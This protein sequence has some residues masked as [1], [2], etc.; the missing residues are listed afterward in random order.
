[1]GT[2]DLALAPTDPA[3]GTFAADGGNLSIDG[4]WDVTALVAAPAGA[5][6]VP[7]AL[8]TR[9]PKQAV[10]ADTS[11]SPTI[12]TVALEGGK[13]AQVYVDPGRAG[14]NELHVT[15]FDAAGG[16][17]PVPTVSLVTVPA[18]G[19][20][21]LGEERELAPGHFVATVDLPPGEIEVDAVGLDP[22]GGQLHVSLVV[23]VTQ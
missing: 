3:A 2:S 1:V 13:S 18:D 12:Y 19:A 6:E 9:V 17:L 20:S 4:I 8:A 15:F 5:V 7:L 10:T 22:D 23:E 11:G 16:A 14:T 21:R